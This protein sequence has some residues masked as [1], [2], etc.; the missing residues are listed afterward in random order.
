MDDS[1]LKSLMQEY[2]LKR[3]KAINE[4]NN[5]KEIL[6][7]ANPRL[8]EIDLALSKEA[9]R[10]SK[11]LLASNDPSLLDDLNRKVDELKK[12]K[13]DILKSLNV[14]DDY[15]KPDFSCKVCNDT[16]YITENGITSMCNCLKQRLFDIEFNKSNISNLK[17]ENFDNFNLQYYSDEVDEDKYKAKLSPR[18]NIEKIKEICIH[19][20]DYFDNIDEKNLLFTGNTGLGKSFLSS[21]IANEL[22][23]KGKTVL[24]Q[25]APVMLDSIIDFRFGK[26]NSK[27]S[28]Q[29]ICD[30]ILNVDLLIID[31]L[32]TESMNSVKFAELFNIINSRLLNSGK[33][34]KTIIS[35]NLS[36]QNLFATY[37][38]RIVSRIVGNY[39]ICYFFGDDIRF[40]KRKND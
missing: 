8:E 3:E 6:Y 22:L 38:E 11:L 14:S 23:K 34:T 24:Y 31:D 33:V 26:S 30:N 18:K 40:M 39:D 35:T 32:G 19:F 27:A 37:D 10:I 21:C 2:S 7:K 36:L 5:R 20:I 15:F 17:N 29:N 13:A 1:N 4:A 28:T 9:I 16:G 25:T 12:Q